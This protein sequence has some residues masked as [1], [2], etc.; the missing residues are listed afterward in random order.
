MRGVECALTQDLSCADQQPNFAEIAFTAPG[1][2]H[3]WLWLIHSARKRQKN[4]KLQLGPAASRNRH[5]QTVLP[6]PGERGSFS[7]PLS[8]AVPSQSFGLKRF[9][10]ASIAAAS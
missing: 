4:I 9:D 6:L 1:G 5:C 3:G 7:L 2:Q 8:A 10:A